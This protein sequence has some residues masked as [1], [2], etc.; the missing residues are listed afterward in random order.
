[1]S[2]SDVLKNLITEK[3]GVIVTSDL[4]E[5]N[6]H[7]QW[8]SKFVEL[9]FLEKVDRGSYISPNAFDDKMYRLQARFKPIIYSHDTALY[10]HGLIDKK[11]IEYTVTVYSGYQTTKL[12]EMGIN[13]FSIKRELFEVGLIEGKTV[14]GRLVRMYD[15]E[16]AICDCIRNRNKVDM[17][18]IAVAVKRY[19]NGKDKNISKLMQHAE[20]FKLSS[21]LK[22]YFEVLL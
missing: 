10:F 18:V 19:V 16:R 11:P 3:Q 4:T 6:I 1:M 8:L 13:I 17:S 21:I 14:F 7:R 22:G 15:A 9:G 5:R 2:C 20:I 12:K